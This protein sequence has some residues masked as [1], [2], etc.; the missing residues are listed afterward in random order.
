MEN[1]KRR[2]MR[3]LHKIFVSKPFKGHKDHLHF[4]FFASKKTH[5]ISDT[6]ISRL[7]FRETTTGLN[8]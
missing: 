1:N 2:R 3:F 5:R 4:Q 7:T 8:L 6:K